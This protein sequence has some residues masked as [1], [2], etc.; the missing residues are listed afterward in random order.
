MKKLTL[1]VLGTTLGVVG[2]AT[3]IEI[4]LPT[5]SASGQT[6]GS[7]P[8]TNRLGPNEC[9]KF[10]VPDS[11]EA[12][13]N[14]DVRVN[15]EILGTI[16]IK[17]LRAAAGDRGLFGGFT[18]LNRDIKGLEQYLGER[19][20]APDFRLKWL[21]ILTETG[22]NRPAGGVTFVDPPSG[23]FEKQWADNKPWYFDESSPNPLPP[24]KEVDPDYLLDN[25]VQG[26]L[27][28]FFDTPRRP[29]NNKLNFWTFLVGD[30]GN[31]TY[32]FLSG[33]S[34]SAAMLAG[35]PF[36]DK[37]GS[38]NWEFGEAFTDRDGN[39]LRSQGEPFQDVNGDGFWTIG[40]P[41]TDLNDNGYLDGTTQITALSPLKL[42]K[43]I[44]DPFEKLVTQ[45]GPGSGY[46][47]ASKLANYKFED[48]LASGR[49]V[50][51]F[52]IPGL[53][54][55]ANF[56]AWINNDLP[57]NR[58]NPNTGLSLSSSYGYGIAY[59][60]NS[61]PVGNGFGSAL[62][63]KVG[64]NGTLNLMVS[65]PNGGARG[66]DKGNY[67]LFVN[68]YDSGESPSFSN[69][70][71]GGGGVSKEMRGLTQQNPILP[72]TAEN[73]WHTFNKVPGCRWYDPYTTYG[74]EFQA[75]E[76]TLFTE[77]LDFPVGEDTEF[78]VTVGNVL[79][80]NFG[81]GSSLDF[82]SLLGKPVSNFKITGISS[83]IGSTP[84]TAFPI[85]LA[86]KDRE[87]SF[88]MRAFS[89]DD[90]EAV[91]EPTTLLATLLA[92]GG[93]GIFKRLKN[94]KLKQP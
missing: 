41:F 83:L 64:S 27:L 12:N 58:C 14:F 81:P 20:G 39:G 70:N 32:D 85:Q 60:D 69:G 77:I 84:E 43:E 51:K 26:S 56:S 68:V 76:D 18:A 93:L 22:D 21:Q 67:E 50:D 3:L 13:I 34:W 23:G 48:S 4:I 66:E 9:T 38:N 61:S 91:P 15:N 72:N 29:V 6:L 2:L 57:S 40:E 30:F 44:T 74:F 37:N 31:N 17:V 63:G 8:C 28:K 82:V 59:D 49:E 16:D 53:T 25:N 62:R 75:L 78:A 7:S 54:P 47:R 5:A 92:A 19:A 79:L 11:P 33:F 65:S 35:E 24:G 73:G 86:F 88:K 42:T 52:S 90:A 89:E 94:Q 36:Q 46:K 71:S 45:F 87:G 1:N 55:D 10:I 80:G